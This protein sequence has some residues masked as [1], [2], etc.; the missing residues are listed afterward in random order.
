MSEAAKKADM[1]AEN[2]SLTAHQRL[3]VESALD[4]FAVDESAAMV[5]QF[6]RDLTDAHNE[7]LRLQ[8]TPPERYAAFDWPEWSGPANS[9]RWAEKRLGKPL[10]KTSLRI[11]EPSR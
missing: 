1:L 5:E 7:I 2:L 4:E 3:E 8:G 11:Q 6:C 10:S 9:I